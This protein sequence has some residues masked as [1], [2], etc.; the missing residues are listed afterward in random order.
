MFSRRTPGQGA[1]GA[2]NRLT[3]SVAARSRPYIDLTVTNPTVVGLSA[4]AAGTLGPLSHPRGARYEPDPR[5][6][7]SAR[8]AIMVRYAA[9][10]VVTDPSR[11]VLT[12]SSSEA[13]AFLFKLL[14]DPGDVVL[15]PA[16]S[17]PL[18]DALA[19]LE[20][21]EIRHYPLAAEDRFCVHASAVERELDAV[22][23]EGARAGAV[24]VVNPNNPTGGSISRPELVA[25]L[26][27]GRERGFG[28][29][30]D[31]VFLDYRFD[32]RP[33]DVR[34]AAAAKDGLV[35]SLGGLSK[36][37][38]LPQLKLGWILAGG[39]P[40]FMGEAIAR[41]EWIADAYLS[42]GTPVMAALSELLASGDRTAAKVR[43]RVLGNHA[44]LS[45][46]FPPGGASEAL[47][48]LAGWAGILRVPAT[49][50]EEELALSLLE[51]Q[52]LL[53]HPG[54]FFDFPFEA[55]LVLSLLPQPEI[56]R[57]G[58]ARLRRALGG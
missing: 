53:V 57:E 14:C 1:L 42:A 29:I 24:V 18:L 6:L 33:D 31:E 36:T 46:A 2:L 45:A 8:E 28:V 39:S 43:E 50:S 4:D 27:L 11:I 25:L 13:Y 44:A 16:P 3:R 26:A 20:S 56:F 41:L 34:V 12:A 55:F 21:L 58:V 23:A 10:E 5:G 52:D 9:E 35:F 22:D 32:D 37:A 48:L 30:S 7:L 17:Y 15:V 49:R 38:A 54:Y 19:G 51:E 47:P 40:D